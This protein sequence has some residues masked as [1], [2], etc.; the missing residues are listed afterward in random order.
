MMS[1]IRIISIAIS[2]MV[3]ITFVPMTGQAAF[4]DELQQSFSASGAVTGLK[5]SSASYKSVTIKWD[6]YKGAQ[7]YEVYRADKKSGKYK[8]IRTL[9]GCFFKDT[10]N[11]K[12]GKKKYYKIRAFASVNSVKVFTRNSSILGA[13]PRLGTPGGLKA[14]GGAGKVTIKWNKVSG[15]K[16]YM[17]YRATSKTGKYKKVCTTKGRT[18]TN[19]TVTTGT[20]YYYKVRAYRKSGKKRYSYY[21]A[22]IEGMALLN[23]AGGFNTVLTEDGTAK[24]SW[25]RVPGASG[26]QL[27]RAAT[28]NGVYKTVCETASTVA[29]DQL[30]ESGQYFYRVR[31][32]AKVNGKRQYGSYSAGGR[33]NAVNQAKS[34]VGCKESNGTHKKIIRVFNAYKPKCGAI[35]YG[36]SWCAAF[37]SA[38]AIKTNNDGIIPIDCYCP[39]M[40]SNFP[41]KTKNKKYTPKGG[42]VVFYDWN[43]NKVP[44][45]VGMIESVSGSSITAIEGN[46]SDAV[47]RRTFKKGYSLLLAYGLPNYSINNAVSYTAPPEPSEPDPVDPVVEDAQVTNEE[48]QTACEQITSQT[49][50]ADAAQPAE[51]PSVIDPAEPETTEPEETEATGAESTEPAEQAAAETAEPAAAEEAVAAAAESIET[52]ESEAIEEAAE[53]EAAE[54]A[55]PAAAEAQ[56]AEEAAPPATEEETAEMI[57]DY[58]QEE[59]PAENAAV[60]ESKFNAFLV[61]GICDEMDIDACV[62]TVTEPDG[63]ESSYNEVVLDGELY[64]L[65]A[66]EEGGVLEKFEP[67]E[68]N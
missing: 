66:T 67:E 18:Y 39:R 48:I 53:A 22:P 43:W 10:G 6:A 30:T 58:I 11:K 4:A 23:G 57:I 24:S 21:S 60:E 47:K 55:E 7:G 63:S 16:K 37:V 26:Y 14:T 59:A 34:W 33:T 64:L 36:T 15:A 62:V 41:K 38:V 25:S 52:P 32:Y 49:E 27:Q 2:L 51:E 45:H 12:L 29:V 68:L 8:K 40:L 31:A 13:A 44:D 19:T 28:A 61:Y 1:S 17:V 5:Q 20:K 65:N 3:A 54:S 42:D 9:K 46:Y 35:G 56:P 50:A